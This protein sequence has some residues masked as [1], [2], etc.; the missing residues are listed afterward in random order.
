NLKGLKLGT[1]QIEVKMDGY[2]VW[3]ESTEIST[4]REKKLSAV[5][6]IL[7]G[8]LNVRS[9]PANATIIIDGSEV[10]YTPADINDLTPGK[11]LVEVK[12]DGY[13][14]WSENVEVNSAK[15][16]LIIAV[17]QKLVGSVNIKSEP[18]NA[19]IIVDGKEVGNT[20]TDIADLKP[21]MHLVEV[22]MDWYQN[23]S[24]S[25]EVNAGKDKHITAIL[26]QLIGSVNIKSEPS[27]AIVIV[28]G[29][30]VGNTPVDICDLKPGKHLVE[31]K[32]DGY[33][34]WSESV[35]VNAGKDNHTTATLQQ[36]VSSVN[37]KSEPSKAIVIVD[38]N[39][40]GNTPVNV[41][42]LKPGK[43]LV[44][45]K[46]EE[47]ETW[48]NKVKVEIGKDVDLTAMLQLKGGSFTMIS[49]PTD[50]TLYIDDQK[51]GTTPLT[52]DA[53]SPGK[54][55]IETR[56]DGY[57]KW[58][59]SI[60]FVHGKSITL[61]A[62]LQINPGTVSITSEPSNAIILINSNEV[63]KTPFAI[64][65]HAP[66]THTV[67][68]RMDGYETWTKSVDF[69]QGK[70]VAI[71]AELKMKEGSISISSN[72]SE[73]F[74]N[75]DGKKT[76]K[77]P[78]TITDLS[79]GTHLV[80]VRMD[81]YED[82]SEN[83]DII[84]DK[85][86]TLTVELLAITAS[87][88]INSNPPEAA[89]YLD[90]E[91]VGTTPDILKSVSIGVHEVGVKL[92]GFAEWKRILNVKNGKEITLNAALQL[93]TG[94][95]SI[96]SDPA[97]AITL[98][99]GNDVGVTPVSLTGIKIGTYDVELQKEGYVSYKKTI[100]IKAGKVNSLTAK[101]MEMT[102]S[103]N[104]NSK[105]SN[106]V[107]IV[108]G[109]KIGNTPANIT[110]LAAGKY[111]LEVMMDCY[112]TWSESVNIDPGKESTVTTELQIKAGSISINSEPSN[113]IILIDNKE[114]GTTPKI[115]TDLSNEEHLLEVRMGGY[116]AWSES[117]NMEPG[118]EFSVVAELQ[119]IAGSVSITS[120]PPNA[121]IL[122]D[123]KKAG[124]TPT[125]LTG[126]LPSN[127][128]VEI[129]IEGY[130][131][132]SESVEIKSDKENSIAAVLHAITGSINIESNPSE[133][134]IFLDGK[135]VST[136]PDTITHA[137]IGIHK[138]E[139]KKEGYAEWSKTLNVK[140]G[141]KIP[142]NAILQP[143]TGSARL[144][145]EPTGA[146][147]FV[148]GEDVG[149]TPKVLTGISPGKHEVE[150]R[151][152]GYDSCVQMLK[153]KN[154]KESL[155]S[156]SLLRK[157][158]S[159]ML[160]SKPENALIYLEGKKYGRT[161]HTINELTPGTYTIELSLDDYQA[162]S[163]K[164]DIV[165][166]EEATINAELQVKP[167]SISVKSKPS[168]AKILIDGREA[169]TTP[170]TIN[171]IECGDHVVKL[172]MDGYGD[173]SENVEVIPNKMSSMTAVLQE[174]AGSV[175]IMSKP[176]KAMILID[177][178]EVGTTPMNV[179]D[180]SH[181]TH[182]VN[183]SMDGYNAWS[184]SVEI[185]AKQKAE[186]SAVLQEA[187]GLVTIKSIPS[188]A[189]I[190]IDG[191]KVG[192]APDKISDIKTGTHLVEVKMDG[193]ENWRENIEIA[194]KEYN[195]TATLQEKT[196]S[197]E[198]KSDPSNATILING[199]K[200]GLTPETLKNIKPGIHQVEV[201]A[202]GFENWSN[203]VEV[204][205]ENK[206]DITALL[207]KAS[208]S[209]NIKS[210]PENAKIYIDGNEVGTT[211]TALSSIPIGA[212]EIEV[213]LDGHEDWK[214]SI[215]IKKEKELSLNAVL[216]IN[217]GS[218]NIESYPENAKIY[219]D[220]IEAGNGPKRFTDVIVGSH[221]IEVL[222]DGY[223]T[224]KRTI[225][226]KPEKETSLTAELKKISSAL[227]IEDDKTPEIS[228]PVTDDASELQI[229]QEKV[230]EK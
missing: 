73:A 222:L 34:N 215:I 121:M 3:S 123:N 80:E 57:E 122:I 126:M 197:I 145:S 98:L 209:I 56:M 103:I 149:K 74:I 97:D 42:D 194:D 77:T 155:F 46:T 133:A 117:F 31:V 168:A 20:P 66:G 169:G 16:N 9:D 84:G 107:V 27:K 76:G 130:E 71:A 49:E 94:T 63:G 14:N 110:D 208:G 189:L 24:E 65:D 180:L 22:K 18:A 1:H 156:A 214:K 188:D 45:V 61:T 32:M 54:H 206:S 17:L 48:S 219:I 21:G 186:L 198:I 113:A 185:N 164:T 127:H 124:T 112:E 166:G 139:V 223:V 60:D 132:W 229:K 81:G 11:Y 165:S 228:K 174:M 143:I 55:L 15:E 35:E 202:D 199:N 167:G 12:M 159:L 171:D 8:S 173:W 39:E 36:L 227:E 144:E 217:I 50:A 111:Q 25:V 88:N 195:L 175:S 62:T 176:S 201:I 2:E 75:I 224:W 4:D 150:I 67:E 182:I 183:I 225:K 29:K 104:I 90:G 134:T 213:K 69:E 226:V 163:E 87:I 131:T 47:Y 147:I 95:A 125:T 205:A 170:E 99:D 157:K 220:G 92:E 161:P 53:P 203:S 152:D 86:N 40:V 58:S 160:I 190:F 91:K 102:G 193:Y 140:K 52:I 187:T 7:T 137:A 178:N 128:N 184:Q 106:A 6:Q 109:K 82:W 216:Q 158:G 28:D 148:D 43:Y 154:G 85:E 116:E 230:K 51:I 196:G 151:M 181:G 119:M 221:E 108:N 141:K 93:N 191:K 138:I 179:G 33:Q 114:V 26:Q 64:T 142:L 68:L 211:P 37:I 192:N 23:W 204:T 218:I 59:R 136:T 120:E 135:E 146:V 210:V 38:G 79:P 41:G 89:I 5:L 83:V 101:L 10:G 129:R 13:E 70:K 115:V 72:P 100:R 96:E 118:I 78:V 105:P 19:I 44:E 172:I 207:Q 162:W 200:T 30:E 212:H 153:I 177:G